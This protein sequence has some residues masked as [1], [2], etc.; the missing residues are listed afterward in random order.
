MIEFPKIFLHEGEYDISLNMPREYDR[1]TADIHLDFKKRIGSEFSTIKRNLLDI[2][3]EMGILGWTEQ[4]LSAICLKES[5][6]KAHLQEDGYKFIKVY[7]P[8]EALALTT[9]IS[10]YLNRLQGLHEQP[11]APWNRMKS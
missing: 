7:D 11:D 1:W 10:H 6:A 5:I 3:E 8:R 2:N 9:M 4:G